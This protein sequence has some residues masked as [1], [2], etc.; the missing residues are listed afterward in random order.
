MWQV[1][2]RSPFVTSI[3]IEERINHN[4]IS[5]FDW[6]GVSGRSSSVFHHGAVAQHTFAL[7]FY[8][9]HKLAYYDQYVKSGQYCTSVQF[10]HFEEKFFELTGKTWGIVGMGAIGRRVAEHAKEF[11]CQVIYCST[12]GKNTDQ[13]Y[14]QVDF[15]EILKR[16]DILSVHAPLTPATRKLFNRDAFAAMKSSAVFINA[17][18]GAIVDEEALAWALENDE[19][20]GAA[21]DVLAKEP[22]RKDNPLLRI[23]DSRKLIITPHIA[24]APKETRERLM[25]GVYENIRAYV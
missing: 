10:S 13:P 17:A 1:P 24:W 19:I 12:S 14:E 5:D 7:M 23:Q 6:R 2:I 9:V 16:S 4:S 8:I 21:L 18:R 15:E 20:A 3:P 25:D 22:M 11:G